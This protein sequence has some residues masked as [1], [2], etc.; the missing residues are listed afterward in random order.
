MDL[1]VGQGLLK[2]DHAGICHARANDVQL[3]QRGG[4]RKVLESGIRH[5]STVQAK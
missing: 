5:G 4:T 1:A 2:L 3:A